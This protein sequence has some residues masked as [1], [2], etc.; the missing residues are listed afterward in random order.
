M[1]DAAI[2]RKPSNRSRRGQS[3][4][5]M[6]VMTPVLFGI[7]GLVYDLGMIYVRQTQLNASTQAATLAGAQAM[8]QPGAT[9]SGTSAIVA[10]YSAA[11]GGRNTSSFLTNAS[12]A[13]GYPQLPCLSTLKTVFS[14]YCY[15]PSSSNAIV[16]KQTATEPLMFLRMFGASTVTLSSMAT[17]SMKGN[18]S[19]PI[20]M[21]IVLD[22]TSSMNSTDLSSNC[23]NLRI[24]CALAGIATLLKTIAPCPPTQT[25]CGT[26][27]NGNVANS[28]DRVSLFAFPPVTTATVAND[29]NC[30][31]SNPTTAPYANPLPAT[32]T[33]QIVGFS[34]DYRTSY[35][36]STLNTAS[37]L[38]DAV[39][40]KFGAPCI[41]VIGGYGTYYAQAIYAAQ[42]KLAA[43]QALHPNSKNVMIIVGDGDAG[44]SSSAMPGAS[45]TSTVYMSTRQQC[46][47][48]VTAA[49][50]ATT[51]GTSVYTVAYGAAAS[52]C[53][54]DTSPSITPCQTMQQMAS[55]PGYFFSDYTATGG[56]SSCISASQ[57]V[58]SLT[59]I[60]KVIANDLTVSKLILNGTL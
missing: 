38:V 47:Q 16:V 37:N 33:Y 20:N 40:G 48:A 10:S 8:A 24:N 60:F 39:S 36:T 28:V 46:H 22:T 3:A 55:T 29:Y 30:G 4:L 18:V 57:P 19:G 23:I 6:T 34:S 51:A 53:S 9:S 26:V 43:Q 12:V 59:S 56:S 45:T 52:G 27:T 5:L 42:A 15:G 58:T 14:V 32:S 35:A 2:S 13:T 1:R 54:T 31:G 21:A 25:S 7:T 17:A 11:S 50:A 49:A 41:H 44:A